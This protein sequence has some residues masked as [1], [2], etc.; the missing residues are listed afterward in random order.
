MVCP[1]MRQKIRVVKWRHPRNRFFWVAIP[2]GASTALCQ[3]VY[4]NI[5][6]NTHS[7]PVEFTPLECDIDLPRNIVEEQL[8]WC[9]TSF[10]LFGQVDGIW[11][12]LLRVVLSTAMKD[13]RDGR[14]DECAS[15]DEPHWVPPVYFQARNLRPNFWLWMGRGRLHV[16]GVL[17][18]GP[19]LM[20]LLDKSNLVPGRL[21]MREGAHSLS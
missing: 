1:C 17:M 8:S 11:W 20:L 9:S 19:G 2:Q 13:N 3:S 12:P 10:S 6:P 18:L 15:D 4:A 16:T 21:P 5:N 7:A 14:R